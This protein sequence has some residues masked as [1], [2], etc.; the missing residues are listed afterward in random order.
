MFPIVRVHHVTRTLSDHYPLW[1]CSDDENVR[2]YKK[3][4]PFR[5][6]A[7]WLKYDR[8]EGVI[9]NAKEGC[10]YGDPVNMVISKVEACC[11]KL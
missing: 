8:C 11:T 2:F 1:L 4:R 5:F 9:K 7:V 10:N 6:E 3:N